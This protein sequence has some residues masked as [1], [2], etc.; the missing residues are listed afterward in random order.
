L[1][2]FLQAQYHIPIGESQAIDLQYSAPPTRAGSSWTRPTIPIRRSRPGWTQDARVALT[3]SQLE[4]S[5]FVR[6]LG[7]TYYAT[8]AFNSISPFGYVQPN[9]APPRTYGVGAKIN[10]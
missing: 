9:Y 7:N 3:I 4:L 1:S 2:T 5:A 6:N 8:A 10:F